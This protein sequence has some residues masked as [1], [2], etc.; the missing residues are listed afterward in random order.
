MA[1]TAYTLEDLDKLA[2]QE[3]HKLEGIHSWARVR[4]MVVLVHAKGASLQITF[5]IPNTAGVIEPSITT[6][7][8]AL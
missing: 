5:E 3:R 4:R 6:R 2:S 8:I 7:N 1:A